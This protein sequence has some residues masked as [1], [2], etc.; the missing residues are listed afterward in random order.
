MATSEECND[1]WEDGYK[2]GYR[3][4]K[5]TNPSVPPRPSTGKDPEQ[6]RKDGYQAGKA[7]AESEIKAP[8]ARS[9]K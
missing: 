3:K 4:V 2:G 8:A 1:A 5:G 9:G 7:K 6:Y